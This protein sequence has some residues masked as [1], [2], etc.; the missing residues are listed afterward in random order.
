MTLEQPHLVPTSTVGRIITGNYLSA[1]VGDQ[2]LSLDLR[3]DAGQK[4]LVMLAEDEIDIDAFRDLFDVKARIHRYSDGRVVIDDHDNVYLD[5]QMVNYGL[6]GNITKLLADGYPI[7]PLARYVAKVAKNPRPRVAEAL[8]EF[9]V[10]S[11]LPLTPE[12][13]FLAIKAV[14][15]D[16]KSFHK[17]HEEI[18]IHDLHGNHLRIE[19]GNITHEPGTVIQFADQSLV[20][21]D[22]RNA[23]AVGLHACSPGYLNTHYGSRVT[24]HLVLVVDPADVAS[25]PDA[26]R[27]TKLRCTRYTVAARLHEVNTIVG[28]KV[29]SC[30]PIEA[31][32]PWDFGV[33]GDTQNLVVA[34]LLSDDYVAEVA[35]DAGKFDARD[36]DMPNAAP[37]QGC[38]PFAAERPGELLKQAIELAIEYDPELDV[39]SGWVPDLRSHLTQLYANNYTDAFCKR[40]RKRLKSRD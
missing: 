33:W 5:G 39:G 25:V 14:G 37:L 10:R 18:E 15:D 2:L 26:D 21:D 9:L 24:P 29:V 12:G 23:C 7:E 8:F 34:N 19:K 16:F 1:Y 38:T 27:Y 13:N 17:G 11:G 3:T 40:I 36:A 4:A 22:P 32:N 30:Y 28:Q 31:P 20:V 6:A 35:R